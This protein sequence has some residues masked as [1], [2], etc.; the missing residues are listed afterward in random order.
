[1]VPTDWGDAVI[2]RGTGRPAD[3]YRDAKGKRVASVTTVLGAVKDMAGLMP[4][5]FRQGALA[6]Y[7]LSEDLPYDP[8][9]MSGDFVDAQI[10]ELDPNAYRDRSG[11]QGSICHAA[12][13]G[14]IYGDCDR[15]RIMQWLSM[16]NNTEEHPDRKRCLAAWAAWCAWREAREVQFVATEVPMVSQRHRFAGTPDAIG[17]VNGEL[18]VLDWKTSSGIYDDHLMQCGAYAILWAETTKQKARQALV[19]RFDKE[20]AGFEE[21]LVGVDALRRAATQFLVALEFR[22]KR[23]QRWRDLRAGKRAGLKG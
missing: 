13:E 17:Y 5:Q 11:R 2:Q 10:A 1:V 6:G 15:L 22:N 7:K 8:L 12:F 19:V 18:T 21:C 4:W 23:Y 16:L 20:G 9:N 3:G 14:D